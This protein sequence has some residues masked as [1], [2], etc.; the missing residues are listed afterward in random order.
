MRHAL[1]DFDAMTFRWTLG[2]DDSMTFL[3]LNIELRTLNY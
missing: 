2:R 1:C 3:T